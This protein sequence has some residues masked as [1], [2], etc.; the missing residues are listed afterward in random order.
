M[1]VFVSVNFPSGVSV[2]WRSR[3]VD[4]VSRWVIAEINLVRLERL[5]HLYLLNSLRAAP[6]AAVS[7]NGPLPAIT[8]FSI[9]I[10]SQRYCAVRAG[11]NACA[12]FSAILTN[13]GL[14][15]TNL[16]YLKWT[17]VH[18]FF[19]A[20]AFFYINFCRYSLYPF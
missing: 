9:I 15:V 2:H 6:I 13:H 16:N 7:P 14:A 8:T 20:R 1:P 18:A 19:A 4:F 10:A 3:L 11:R 17:H 12:A 5:L